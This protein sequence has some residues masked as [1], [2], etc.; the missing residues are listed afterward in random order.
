MFCVASTSN[1]L[2]LQALYNDLSSLHRINEFTISKD[3]ICSCLGYFLDR[4]KSNAAIPLNTTMLFG[5]Q[6]FA[7]ARNQ[8][9]KMKSMIE[10][11]S[12]IRTDLRSICFLQNKK[13]IILELNGENLRLLQF[14][15]SE[16][17]LDKFEDKV[18]EDLGLKNIS[19]KLLNALDKYCEERGLEDSNRVETKTRI[20]NLVHGFIMNEHFE[21]TDFKIIP[22]KDIS[23]G[24]DHS[25]KIYLTT[26]DRI[27]KSYMKRLEARVSVELYHLFFA[28]VSDSIRFK[29]RLHRAPEDVTLSEGTPNVSRSYGILPSNNNAINLASLVP[30]QRFNNSLAKESMVNAKRI[31]FSNNKNDLKGVGLPGRSSPIR[32]SMLD[33][34]TRRDSEARSRHLTRKSEIFNSKF[35]R[36]LRN[37]LSMTIKNIST[38]N[39]IDDTKDSSVK[40]FRSTMD[41]K[42]LSRAKINNSDKKK[43]NNTSL[44]NSRK[45]TIKNSTIKKDFISKKSMLIKAKRKSMVFDNTF[46]TVTRKS[47]NKSM[48][49]DLGMEKDKLDV[50][51]KFR[52]KYKTTTNIVDEE[53]EYSDESQQEEEY[54]ETDEDRFVIQELQELIEILNGKTD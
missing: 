51:R 13:K 49:Q 29:S 37:K 2:Q 40:R 52:A 41:A 3:H 42:Y 33:S 10:E 50:M 22:I 32:K 16:R 43:M 38:L 45:S 39:S 19:E 9:S 46:K 1:Q 11:F 21:Q 18:F 5:P 7:A 47:V 6:L 27:Y 15:I 31:T 8:N 34:K 4:S 25:Y 26:V 44:Y 35:S 12:V 20:D 53:G 24:K 48:L 17:Q 28:D 14:S 54:E 30:N 36:A 23:T